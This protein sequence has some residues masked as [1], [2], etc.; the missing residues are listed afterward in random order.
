MA[1]STIT[2]ISS[3][4]L[5][6]K[7]GFTYAPFTFPTTL[8]VG[9]NTI[10]GPS[11]TYSGGSGATAYRNGNYL[12]MSK[13]NNGVHAA[14]RI[15]SL[16][17]ANKFHMTGVNGVSN[18]QTT[19]N[20]SN[21]TVTNDTPLQYSRN[22]YSTTTGAYVGGT[23]NSAENVKTTYNGSSTSSG[24]YIE[25]R[26]PF[27]FLLQKFTLALAQVPQY[28]PKNIRVLGSNNGTTW[29]QVHFLTFGG[30]YQLNTLV[31]IFDITA[32][33][34]T[35]YYHHRFVWES[36]NIQNCIVLRNCVVDGQ[37]QLP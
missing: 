18:T 27:L 11:Y 24:E 37:A 1:L 10:T 34:T 35:A 21:G 3:S 16:D 13:Y 5:Y 28:G 36:N 29:T 33:N 26:F 14:W 12:M 6:K 32:T 8:G 4:S 20:T 2:T 25:L 9:V 30:T 7:Q 17:L 23:T 15:F 22:A 31:Q 19:Y